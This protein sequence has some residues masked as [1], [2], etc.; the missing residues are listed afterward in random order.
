MT[1]NNTHSGLASKQKILCINLLENFQFLPPLGVAAINGSLLYH[2][3]NS[4]VLVEYIKTQKPEREAYIYNKR[5]PLSVESIRVALK[6]VH[7]YKPTVICYS[8]YDF[9]KESTLLLGKTIRAHFPEIKQVMGGPEVKDLLVADSL[10][11][12]LN[13]NFDYLVKGEG[14]EVIIKIMEQIDAGTTNQ[15]YGAFT[16]PYRSS[17]YFTEK[18]DF[19]TQVQDLNTLPLPD[20]GSNPRFERYVNESGWWAGI[21]INISRGCSGNC[22]FC[23]VKMYSK[24]VR[25][26][27]ADHIMNEILHQTKKY[28]TNRFMIVDDDPLSLVAKEE[29]DKLLRMLRDSPVRYDWN[30]YNAKL[31]RALS[32]DDR[33][34]LLKEA[35]LG[36]VV[37]GFE[38]ASE[39]VRKHMNKYFP[40]SES[41]RILKNFKKTG[42]RVHV[43]LIYCYPSETESDF[44]ITVEWV[45]E[46]GDL[47]EHIGANIFFNNPVYVSR[48]PES[49]RLVPATPEEPLGNWENE[50]INTRIMWSRYEK[51]REVLKGRASGTYSI[52]APSGAYTL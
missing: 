39:E 12:D 44:D 42:I 9:N 36:S 8:I 7:E 23:N 26:R 13:E 28:K 2:G 14:E 27:N 17:N 16:P 32:D 29:T 6:Y 20:F 45:R 46:Y 25:F 19:K 51:L 40:L 30:I 50:L 4:D 21:P 10:I 1:L 41:T 47:V 35:G 52:A 15:V 31:D 22:T 18:F 34:V 24:A 5:D 49:I 11:D 37:F 38:S 33:I 43:N 3:Y 48:F